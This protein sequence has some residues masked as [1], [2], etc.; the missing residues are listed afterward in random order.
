MIR[1]PLLFDSDSEKVDFGDVLDIPTTNDSYTVDFWMRFNATN[2][3]GTNIMSK[4]YSITPGWSVGVTSSEQMA[5]RAGSSVHVP[6]VTLFTVGEL[7]HYAVVFDNTA[8]SIAVYKDGE[9]VEPASSGET[10]SAG[11]NGHSFI[12]GGD[13]S[14]P[15]TKMTLS[16][17]RLWHGVKT[18]DEI[19]AMMYR[20]A[21]PG[22]FPNLVG[23]WPM[24]EGSGS[25]VKDRFQTNDG[26]I[27]G[28][29]YTYDS[30]PIQQTF[31]S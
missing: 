12:I 30:P 20:R 19:R 8:N 7:A 25:V 28:A 10:S 6:A 1:V 16:E 14:N 24:D 21:S 22:D 13:G 18:Q 31:P 2:T 29:T 15:S 5:V 27:T 9:L 4:G 3:V 17:V 23:Y 11:P 26:T